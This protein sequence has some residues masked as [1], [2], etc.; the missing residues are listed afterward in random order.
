M[1]KCNII[2]SFPQCHDVARN[3]LSR[4]LRV[5][6]GIVAKQLTAE[7]RVKNKV[8][9]SSKSIAMRQAVKKY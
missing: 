3:I 6:I 1:L 2:S 9:L 7:Q 8:N 4:W 5:R